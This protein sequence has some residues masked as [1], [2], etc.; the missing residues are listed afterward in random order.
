MPNCCCFF[1]KHCVF[2]RC[3]ATGLCIPKK[4]VCDGEFDCRNGQDENATA[5]CQSRTA[6]TDEQFECGKGGYCV[7]RSY[8]CDGDKVGLNQC[9]KGI[10]SR[11]SHLETLAQDVDFSAV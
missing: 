3:D 4:W 2:F 1:S 11:D 10:D 8:Y 9:L 7:D 6:C 5:G